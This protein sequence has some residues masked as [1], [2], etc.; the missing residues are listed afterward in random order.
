MMREHEEFIEQESQSVNLGAGRDSES[1]RLRL[2]V[3]KNSKR[4]SKM[5][6]KDQLQ[7]CAICLD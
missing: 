6:G 7:T 2:S 5:S 4:L 1:K 3:A